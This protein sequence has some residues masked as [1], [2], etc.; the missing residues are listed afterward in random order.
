MDKDFQPQL[1]TSLFT[2]VPCDRKTCPFLHLKDFQITINDVCE[3]SDVFELNEIAK[4]DHTV[5][6]QFTQR[7]REILKGP[8]PV[9]CWVCMKPARASDDFF[10]PCCDVWICKDCEEKWPF[11]R[12]CPKCGKKDGA[13]P[14][15]EE[16]VEKAEK[17]NRALLVPELLP[18]SFM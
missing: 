16:V 4:H 8:Q 9:L 7:D 17:A 12:H 18:D 15:P 14:A 11:P 6:V 10:C 2:G 3:I 5:Q 1:C 13:G